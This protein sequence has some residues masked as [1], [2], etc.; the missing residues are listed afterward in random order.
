MISDL[1]GLQEALNDLLLAPVAVQVLW[2]LLDVED[3]HQILG[4][5]L[6]VAVLV[7]LPVGLRDESDPIVVH[8]RLKKRACAHQLVLLK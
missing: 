1:K 4:R 6:A 8:R 7:Q 2:V 3:A 5:H